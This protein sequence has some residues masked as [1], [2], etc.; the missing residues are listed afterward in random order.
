MDERIKKLAHNLVSYSCRVGKGDQV[1]I[2]YIG[3]ETR[4]LAKELV[5]EVYDAGGIPYVHYEDP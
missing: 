1:Y 3:R 5:R 2:N 4:A